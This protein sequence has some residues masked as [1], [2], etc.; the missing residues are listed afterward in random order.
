MTSFRA[1][2]TFTNCSI[3]R[4]ICGSS[5]FLFSRH[6][7]TFVHTNDRLSHSI[8]RANRLHQMAEP[9]NENEKKKKTPKKVHSQ[10][11]K[12]RQRYTFYNTVGQ[13]NLFFK[14]NSKAHF[15]ASRYNIIRHRLKKRQR[16]YL[17]FRFSQFN[18]SIT[19][20]FIFFFVAPARR[21]LCFAHRHLINILRFCD[22]M[23]IIVHAFYNILRLKLKS[24]KKTN[25]YIHNHILYIYIYI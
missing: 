13:S 9:R 19:I 12:K 6:R 2:I 20:I 8:I 23:K 16:F 25:T 14:E 1:S 10:M 11:N 18:S 15:S 4:S 22:A 21:A 7:S 3:G 5:I 24:R 17:S